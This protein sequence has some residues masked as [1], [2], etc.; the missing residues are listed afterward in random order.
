MDAIHYLTAECNYGGR[1]TDQFDQLLIG[2]LLN[3]YL[4]NHSP[5]PRYFPTVFSNYDECIQFIRNLPHVSSPEGS[6]LRLFA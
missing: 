2:I 4:N 1:I 6:F 3:K 5:D